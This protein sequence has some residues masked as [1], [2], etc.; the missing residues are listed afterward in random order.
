MRLNFKTVC[1]IGFS[2]LIAGCSNT[3]S[4][5]KPTNLPKGATVV[6]LDNKTINPANATTETLNAGSSAERATWFSEGV[7]RA[8]NKSCTNPKTRQF[9]NEEVGVLSFVSGTNGIWGVM[10]DQGE[11]YYVFMPKEQTGT[12]QFILCDPNS[13]K[14]NLCTSKI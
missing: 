5:S 2:A 12:A 11:R 3:S 1:L 7:K 14:L 13:T 4:N 10:C 8:W 6:K 9:S